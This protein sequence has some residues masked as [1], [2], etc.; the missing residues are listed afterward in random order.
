MSE[1]I[2][3]D[4]IAEN[5]ANLGKGTYIQIQEAKRVSNRINPKKTSRRNV[6]KMSK[7]KDKEGIL[8]ASRY[9]QDFPGSLAGQ[10]FTCNVSDPGS[11]P[12]SRSSLWRKD[13]LATLVILASPGGSDGKQSA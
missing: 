7:I 12:G 3:E 2:F 9:A 8:K 5:F 6:M 10:E 1:T 11:I 13:R 4:L